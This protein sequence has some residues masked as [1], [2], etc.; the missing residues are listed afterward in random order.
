MKKDELKEVL[1]WAY[2]LGF[3]RG[4]NQEMD[5]QRREQ[6]I[7]SSIRRGKILEAQRS[8]DVQRLLDLQ[9]GAS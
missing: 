9:G 1:D 6:E 5:N 3:N 2:Q 8:G 7:A 4:S